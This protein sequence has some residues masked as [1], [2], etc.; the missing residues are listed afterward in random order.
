MDK[1]F[2]E[3][4]KMR[5]NPDIKDFKMDKKKSLFINPSIPHTNKSYG[6]LYVYS[7]T[8]GHLWI[9]ELIKIHGY[10]EFI[11]DLIWFAK[12]NGTNLIEWT[13]TEIEEEEINKLLSKYSLKFDRKIVRGINVLDYENELNLLKEKNHPYHALVRVF[14]MLK[15]DLLPENFLDFSG[16]IEEELRE[17]SPVINAIYLGLNAA[18]GLDEEET[19]P[20]EEVMDILSEF[21]P[22]MVKEREMKYYPKTGIEN[23]Y[24]EDLPILF[25]R[26]WDLFG[27]EES[28]II[29]KLLYSFRIIKELTYSLFAVNGILASTSIRILFDNYWQTKYLIENNEVQDYKEFALDRMRLHILK[30]TGK[31]DVEDIGIIMLASKNN[32]LDPIPIHGDYFKKSAREYAIQLNLKEEYDKY[33]E[34]NSEFIHASLTAVLSGLM[35]ECTN[36]E[37]LSHLTIDPSSSRYINAIPH[38]F[39]II[40]SHISLVND[41]LGDN[42]LENVQLE[43]YFFTDRKSFLDH[44]ETV[45]EKHRGTQ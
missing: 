14:H 2:E 8:I 12:T 31:E 40:N 15:S 4:L 22:C 29:S 24:F 32:L 10:G 45:Y 3:M 25:S 35:V 36:P 21:S 9:I 17:K 39:E 16:N 26:N 43:D 7:L 30:R 41:Y 6:E 18:G 19:F 34:Y 23:N 38:M 1:K 5:I 37:H 11:K 28:V 44:M 27:D 33:Y 42:T 13:I 20:T